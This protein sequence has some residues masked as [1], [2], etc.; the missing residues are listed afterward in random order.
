[1]K[2]LSW[3]VLL[4]LAIA[5]LVL[6]TQ[7]LGR[8]E[9]EPV[10]ASPQVKVVTSPAPRLPR[11]PVPQAR[12]PIEKTETLP[13]KTDDPDQVLEDAA[14]VGMTTNEAEPAEQPVAP[15][16]PAPEAQLDPPS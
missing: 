9:P 12:P 15:P 2:A 5:V 14:A 13:P 4:A 6:A 8:R 3:I 7:L 10:M 11:P 1:M 16:P